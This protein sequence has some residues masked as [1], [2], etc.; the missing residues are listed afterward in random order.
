MD[1]V[2]K[3]VVLPLLSSVMRLWGSAEHPAPRSDKQFDKSVLTTTIAQLYHD[4][5]GQRGTFRTILSNQAKEIG[6]TFMQAKRTAISIRHPSTLITCYANY[7]FKC[8][9]NLCKTP[10]QTNFMSL[11]WTDTTLVTIWFNKKCIY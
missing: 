7:L 10:I 11:P 2:L 1:C 4:I 6:N 3:A 5:V 9:L 8:V